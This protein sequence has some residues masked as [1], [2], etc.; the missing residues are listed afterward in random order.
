MKFTELLNL[1]CPDEEDYGALA[2]Y[3]QFLATSIEDKVLQQRALMDAYD[4]LRTTIWTNDAI[5]G[6]SADGAEVSVEFSELGGEVFYS[7][8]TDALAPDGTRPNRIGVDTGTFDESGLY[9]FGYS[10]NMVETGAVTDL[11]FRQ[12]N[13]RV[14][15]LI[16]AGSFIAAECDRIVQAENIAGGSFLGSNV[17]FKVDS[18]FRDYRVR[19]VWSHSNVGSTVQI[20]IN[21]FW[22]WLTRLGNADAIEVT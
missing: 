3:M 9:H 13:V 1:P 12:V 7:N 6:P 10:V 21:G 14:E 15:K 2:L 16:G 18:N 17:T 22:M 5:L 20:P 11:S 19:V 4:D 8:R